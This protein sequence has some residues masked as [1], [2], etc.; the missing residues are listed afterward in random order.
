MKRAIFYLTF[1]GVY[2]VSN[3]IGT[4]TQTFLNGIHHHYSRFVELFG[5]VA[6][7]IVS[8]VYCP[9]N[10]RNYS[11][12]LLRRTKRITRATNGA[13]H[14]LP[15]D[16]SYP[17]WSRR[18]WEAL[19]RGAAAQVRA[20]SVNYDQSIVIAI[21]PPFLLAPL[22]LNQQ[23]DCAVR[24]IDCLLTLYGSSFIHDRA[25]ISFERLEWEYAGLASSR[26]YEP[27]Y[28]AKVC[29]FMK[30][31]L[32]TH[33]GAPAER[34]IPYES[35]LFLEAPDF[36][37]L[38]EKHIHR[39]LSKYDVPTDRDLVFSFGRGDWIKGFDI[40]INALRHV[41]RKLH[42]ILIAVP[43]AERMTGRPCYAHSLTKLRHTFTFIDAYNREL[44]I[45]LAQW[46]RSSIVVCPSRGEPFSNIPFE[47]AMWARRAGPVCL[48]SDIDGFPYQITHNENGFLFKAGDTH[49]LAD[50]IRHILSLDKAQKMAIRKRAAA[51]VLRERDFLKNFSATL[52]CFWQ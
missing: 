52:R 51:R 38:C 28:I 46:K 11:L 48:C 45:A 37:P 12:S 6:I 4:Q 26:V 14:L 35:S 1:N 19:S 36:H 7:H 31:H 22:Y 13:L 50:A 10:T 44:P 20:C 16:T 17:F 25:Q 39:T 18:T 32:V 49:D 27:I 24:N 2:N 41:K 15:F 8:P 23:C 33:Y 47:V 42:F 3:G 34:F 21:D 43:P 9:H 30:E 40:V 29:D 5:K